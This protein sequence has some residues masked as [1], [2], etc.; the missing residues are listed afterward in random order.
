MARIRSIKPEFPQSETV[1]RL[2]RDARGHFKKRAITAAVRREVALRY[3]AMP[4]GRASARCHYCQRAGTITW[5]QQRRGEGWPHFA[6]LELDHVDPEILGGVGSAEN[7][8][9]ACLPCNRGKGARTP[10]DWRLGRP[11]CAEERP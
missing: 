10:M 2:S 1:G 11:P 9:L 7:L 3:G 6:G 4:G 5:F 8:V